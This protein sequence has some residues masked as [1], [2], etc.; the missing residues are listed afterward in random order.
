MSGAPTVHAEPIPDTVVKATTLDDLIESKRREYLALE[1][2]RPV[3][4]S[5]PVLVTAVVPVRDMFM[6]LGRT[7]Y[8]LAPG[9]QSIP[10]DV[11]LVDGGSTDPCR[12]I[13]SGKPDAKIVPWLEEKL[14]LHKV[15]VLEPVIPIDRHFDTGEPLDPYEFKNR[16]VE[17]LEKKLVLEV[18]TKYVLFVDADVEIPVDCVRHMLDLLELEGDDPAKA[19]DG[20]LTAM[21]GI[22]YDWSADHVKLGC[23]LARMSVM[24]DFD[25]RSDAGCPCRWTNQELKRLGWK[26]SYVPPETVFR[27]GYGHIRMDGTHGRYNWR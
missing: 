22:L 12:D 27:S 11:I 17:W 19:P 15:T 7:L 10:I 3:I 24:K 16:N 18:K 20:R 2:K 1:A 26:V 25:F 23:A 5:S 8:R 13:L 14:G 4:T 9:A 6:T 21:T